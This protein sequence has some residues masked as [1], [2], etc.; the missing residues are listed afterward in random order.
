MLSFDHEAQERGIAL[1]SGVG[2]GTVV[3][4]FLAKQA[5]ELL[6]DAEQLEVA[7]PL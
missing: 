6:P 7:A 4:N 1:I 2:F 3:T 5:K